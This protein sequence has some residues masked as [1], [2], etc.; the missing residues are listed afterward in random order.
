MRKGIKKT[1]TGVWITLAT[2]IL[3]Y[4]WGNNPDMFF[5]PPK[6]FSNWL[7]DMYGSSNAEELA[8]LELLYVFS[9][10]LLIVSLLTFFAFILRKTMKK[11]SNKQ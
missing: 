8:D 6:A 5:Q 1:L 11:D 3:A 2:L 9:C 10:S 4:I 7:V